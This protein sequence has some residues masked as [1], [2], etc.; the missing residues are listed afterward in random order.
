MPRTR[1]I[2]LAIAIAGCAAGGTNAGASLTE[3][4]EP[5]DTVGGTRAD[6]DPAIVPPDQPAAGT[7][8]I[9]LSVLPA[10]EAENERGERVQSPRPIAID[11]DA[12]RFAPRALDPV[13]VI[14][15]RRFRHYRHPR[16]GV[17]RFVIADASLLESGARVAIEYEGEAPIV[18]TD[19]LAIPAEVRP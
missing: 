10:G 19:A 6:R 2:V 15:Q 13:L 16:P 14:G 3:H 4:A 18:L 9:T 5:G 7:L 1:S 17:L 12:H 8:A 11:L